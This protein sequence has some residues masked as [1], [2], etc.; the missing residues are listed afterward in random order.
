MGETAFFA[1]YSGSGPENYQRYFVPAIGEP[2]AQDLMVAADLRRGERVLDVACGT[3][4]VAQL[5]A[6]RV[7]P[8]G[9][10]AGLDINPGM[11]AV[12]RSV[13]SPHQAITWHQGSAESMPLPDAA[14]DVVVCQL[15][16]QFMM[17][18]AAALREMHR[19]QAP[20]GRLILSVTGPT[21][22]SFVIFDR[23]LSQH[24]SPA[25]SSFVH[26]VFSLYQPEELRELVGAAGFHKVAV[27]TVARKL[28]L[29]TPR[30]FLWQY[31][32][33]TPLI[34]ALAHVNDERRAALEQDVV[35][36]WQ[37]FVEDGAMTVTPPLVLV[38]AQK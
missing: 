15:G 11:L 31:I 25:S 13:T 20:G 8:E 17:D 18:K 5:A 10:V 1:A 3:G 35:T 24:I 6:D 22:P 38:T 28:V 7:G 36:S 12:A 2:F 33:S 37:P 4:I 34:D 19:V 32:H 29:P 21:P 23:A 30:A 14:F 16:L 9:T 26:A 27:R